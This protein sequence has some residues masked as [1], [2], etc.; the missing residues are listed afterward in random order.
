MPSTLIQEQYIVVPSALA[1]TIGLEE[2][3]LL[4]VLSDCLIHRASVGREGAHWVHLPLADALKLLP[5]WNEEQIERIARNLQNL[6]IIHLED[7]PLARAGQL[8]FAL[9]DSDDSYPA[10][11]VR[12]G[13]STPPAGGAS[14][15]E[16]A[17]T[18]PA[19]PPQHTTRRQ[20][21]LAAIGPSRGPFSAQPRTPAA[22]TPTAAAA[23][24][25]PAAPPPA[26][27]A[28]VR[29]GAVTLHESWQPNAELLRKLKEINGIPAEFA[30]QLVPEFVL[31]WRDRQS[32]TFSWEARF[33]KHATREWRQA[34]ANRGEALLSATTD[35]TDHAMHDAWQPSEDAC[36]ILMRSGIDL[37][38]IQDAVPEFVLYW[39]DR[40]DTASTWDSRFIAH[41]RRQWARFESS[42]RYDTEPHRIEAGWQPSADVYDI[43]ALA[44]IDVAFA[45]GTVAEFVIYWRDTNQV[46]NSWN[47][48]FLQHVKTQWARRHHLHP[49][50]H[51]HGKTHQSAAEPD[52]RGFVDKHTDQSWREGL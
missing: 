41:I 34:A 25:G 20:F 14:S 38:F 1:A 3:V 16:Q 17:Q 39:R 11:A 40:G 22:S 5:F 46:H 7:P 19:Q 43:L 49:S 51:N 32:A 47:T 24:P 18:T 12:S 23:T 21:D 37:Q 8:V 31:Y 52:R 4:Q 6:G 27:S 15:P 10:Q 13:T 45:K 29:R 48:R 50:G 28:P 36:Q 9:N 42:M 30:L 26:S 35:K 33:M 2:A 44:N